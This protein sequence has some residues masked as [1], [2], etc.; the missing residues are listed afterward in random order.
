MM[1]YIEKLSSIIQKPELLRN[2]FKG[3]AYLHQWVPELSTA[4]GNFGH[5]N[6]AKCESH[7][8][9]MKE[10]LEIYAY[11]DFDEARLWADKIKELQKMPV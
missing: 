10:I 6:L 5:I 8:S 1:E 11:K 4:E 7:H 3:W 9:Q 2:Y